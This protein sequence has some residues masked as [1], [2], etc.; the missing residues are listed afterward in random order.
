[1]GGVL[2]FDP[3]GP[4]SETVQ[5]LNKTDNA[6]QSIDLRKSFGFFS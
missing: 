1:M 5:T 3:D 6:F 4:I 2:P